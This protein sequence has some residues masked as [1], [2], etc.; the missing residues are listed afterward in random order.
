MPHHA[1]TRLDSSAW[2]AA[3]IKHRKSALAPGA[4]QSRGTSNVEIMYLWMALCRKRNVSHKIGHCKTSRVISVYDG[5]DSSASAYTIGTKN[6]ESDSTFLHLPRPRLTESMDDTQI[7]NREPSKNFNL[8]RYLCFCHPLGLLHL[9]VGPPLESSPR[10]IAY[11]RLTSRK[12]LEPSISIEPT[13][14]RRCETER[15]KLCN[16]L[17][18][19]ILVALRRR[20]RNRH[21]PR[22]RMQIKSAQCHNSYT[23]A[24]HGQATESTSPKDTSGRGNDQ[25]A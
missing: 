15:F 13:R 18:C 22:P 7:D 10:K 24:R 3:F 8:W 2:L 21:R 9:P 14:D 17:I 23:F 25:Y 5:C 16:G 6:M 1:R 4:R 19:A 20:S 12:P 11:R